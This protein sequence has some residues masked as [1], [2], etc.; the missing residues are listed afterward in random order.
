MNKTLLNLAVASACSVPVFV[1]AQ[2][3]VQIY[4]TINLDYDVVSATGASAAGALR[5]GQLGVTPTGITSS[6]RDRVSSNSS[7]IGFRGEENLGGGLRAIWQV[8]SAAN[9][10]NQATF[11]NNTANGSAV[12][13]GFATRNTNIGL[14]G[15]WGTLFGGQWNTPYKDLNRAVDPFYLTGIAYVAGIIGT[16][17]F[18]ITTATA[19]NVGLSADGK[20]FA[21]AGN[22]SFT[23]RQ[24][25]SLQYW[26]PAFD[27]FKGRFVYSPNEG[28]TTNSAALNQVSPHLW[29]LSGEYENGPVYVAYGY[30]QHDDYFG[31]SAIA[32]AAQAVTV[33]AAG[34][35]SSA[36]SRD[37]GNKFV[38]RYTTGPARL[39]LVYERLKYDQT[40][41][42]AAASAF[43]SYDRN[44]YA[45][46]TMYAIGPG[47][48]RALYGSAQSGSCTLVG[49]GACIASGLGAR[50]YSL[51]YSYNFSKRTEMYAL[52]TRLANDP[53]ANYQFPV[54][55]IAVAAGAA[56]TGYALGVRHTF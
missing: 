50:Q 28:K 16:P 54:N 6:P 33:A 34:G 48:L 2:S 3:N 40:N 42:A 20:T 7:N 43:K 21:N 14:S 30:E 22:A 8:E 29:G 36:S 39:G 10:D 12:G 23:R 4:G 53:N 31:L 13:G 5:P 52:Y 55:G 24:G 15:N 1:S 46:T 56:S 25:N 19:G 17:G 49:G 26:T 18:G 32:P 45:L 11:G 35:G 41:S 38:A 27:G 44:S 51:G 37:S 9:F 47:T